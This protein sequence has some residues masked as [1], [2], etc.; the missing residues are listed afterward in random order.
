MEFAFDGSGVV[1]GIKGVDG[2]LIELNKNIQENDFS[3]KN[4]WK[5]FTLAE[6]ASDAINTV[7]SKVKDFFVDGIKMAADAEELAS[8]FAIVFKDEAAEAAAFVDSFSDA[9]GKTDE[10]VTEWM[11]GMQDTFVPLG[12]AR[13]AARKLSEQVV[14]LGVDLGSF[15]NIEAQQA[16]A[17]M[18][19][20]LIGNH[21]AGRKY[22]II[23]TENALSQELMRMGIEKGTKAASE[24]EKVLARL[25]IILRSTTD[26]QGDAIRT[27]DSKMNLWR[28][29]KTW[30]KDFQIFLGQGI[31][32]LA[33]FTLRWWKEL[34]AVSSILLG[35]FA[36]MKA[37][38][39][40]TA[41]LSFASAIKSFAITVKTTIMS[42][43]P[44]LAGITIAIAATVAAIKLYSDAQDKAMRRIVESV[45][46]EKKVREELRFLQANASAEELQHIKRMLDEH[47]RRGKELPEVEKHIL[48]VYSKRLQ[49]MKKAEELQRKEIEL[50]EEKRKKAEELAGKLGLLTTKGY[51][52]LR[53]EVEFLGISYKENQSIIVQSENISENFYNKAIE[54]Q[55]AY[56]DN[57]K[58][59]P[60]VLKQIIERTKDWFSI[61][62]NNLPELNEK[63]SD[64]LEK[65]PPIKT[66][67]EKIDFSIEALQKELEAMGKKDDLIALAADIEMIGEGI[68]DDVLPEMKKWGAAIIDVAGLFSK[69]GI[70][71]GEAV[72]KISQGI[73]G[74]YD[75]TGGLSEGAAGMGKLLTG[76]IAG[77]ISGI[78]Q[79]ITSV[80]S[81][82]EKIFDLFKGDGVGEAI[83]RERELIEISEEMES[84]IRDLEEQLG[85]THAATSLL[86]DQLIKDAEI[87]EEN[88]SNYVVRTREILA[89]LDRG[90]LSLQETKESIGKSFNELIGEAG[91]LGQEGSREL[92]ALMGDLRNRGMEVAEVQKYVNEE[93]NRGLDAFRVYVNGFDRVREI[94]NHI[95]ELESELAGV[96]EGTEKHSE[97]IA[98]LTQEYNRL[99][100]S[101]EDVSQNWKSIEVY[102]IGMF[103]ALIKE[104]ASYVEAIQ[105]MGPELEKLSRIAQDSG[106]EVSG[107]FADMLDMQGFITENE[108]L[109]NRIDATKSMLESLGN[110]GY[111]TQDIFSQFQIDAQS[112]FDALISKTSDATQAY[113]LMG[114]ELGK[115]AWYAAQYGYELDES[116]KKMIEQAQEHG[117]NMDAM[118]PPQEKMVS[119]LEELVKVLGG[120]IPYAM[121]KFSESA[122][123]NFNRAGGSLSE[124]SRMARN[125]KLPKL[126]PDLLQFEYEGFDGKVPGFASGTGGA[127]IDAPGLFTLGERGLEHVGWDSAGKMRVQPVESGPGP[128]TRHQHSKQFNF[129]IVQTNNFNISTTTESKEYI[130]DAVITGVRDNYRT[131]VS[132]IKR[133]IARA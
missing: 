68:A 84:Q 107:A 25:N 21:E 69:L 119:L 101:L 89:D 17:D 73:Q 87:N 80:V 113:Q 22:G 1:T 53:E 43:N 125:L 71:S 79:G 24:Q 38:V 40:Q 48:D 18:Q 72:E 94:S 96:R 31:L 91:K 104:G 65:L 120:Q 111:L 90:A 103:N 62:L 86:M 74:V 116:T 44:V 99:D 64:F 127:W 57:N 112:Q 117:V 8:Q 81:G 13:E 36:F 88:F 115:L 110:T 5:Q 92:I 32:A 46:E 15:K 59:V 82:M 61:N 26:A 33:D 41:I 42:I 63:M 55:Q 27:A 102:T 98:E 50:F 2:A 126:S 108:T 100:S 133:E 70:I 47:R 85:D 7:A 122:E 131:L 3:I 28:R 109:V 118:I 132:D 45:N 95:K 58:R 51:K 123:L 6:L 97:I 49:E 130:L 121:E 78:V 39:I 19:T 106:L 20:M 11:A 37:G 4:L 14:T 66:E 105:Q 30:W 35:I 34:T 54:L 16:L 83:D 77:G 56:L 128:A 10:E 23:I 29:I 60:L 124:F 75:I 9:V 52:E 129:N 12:F 93:I 67:F 76:D 114:P